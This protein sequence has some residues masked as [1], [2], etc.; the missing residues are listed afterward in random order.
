MN[1]ISL[2]DVVA[3]LVPAGELPVGAVG[4]VVEVLES[5]WFMI[6]FINDD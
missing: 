3:L 6:E 2:L 1:P 4:T 5:G